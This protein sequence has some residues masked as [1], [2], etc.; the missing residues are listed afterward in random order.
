[1]FCFFRKQVETTR[2]VLASFRKDKLGFLI[3]VRAYHGAIQSQQLDEGYAFWNQNDAG[4]KVVVSTSPFGRSGYRIWRK[5]SLKDDTSF[6]CFLLVQ[7]IARNLLLTQNL[8][9]VGYHIGKL[10]LQVHQVPVP[11]L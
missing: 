7:A 9:A 10:A 2:D 5:S 8:E 3:L 4:I 6:I 11:F 1:M